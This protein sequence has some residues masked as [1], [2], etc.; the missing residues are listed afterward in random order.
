MEGQ[1]IPF[2]FGVEM[3]FY[4][5]WHLEGHDRPAAPDEFRSHPGGPVTIARQALEMQFPL[6]QTAVVRALEQAIANLPQDDSLPIVTQPDILYNEWLIGSDASLEA[7]WPEQLPGDGE[8]LVEAGSG[9]VG[10]E[11]VSPAL[12]ATQRSIEEIRKVCRFLYKTFWI[13]TPFQAGLHVHVG[14][15]HAWLP[16]ASLRRMAALLYSADPILAQMYPPYRI[17][18]FYCPSTRLYATVSFGAKISEDYLAGVEYQPEDSLPPPSPMKAI[19]QKIYEGTRAVFQLPKDAPKPE[20]KRDVNF[21]PRP[22]KSALVIQPGTALESANFHPGME[23]R[24]LADF[25]NYR[26]IPMMDAVSELL[27]A[28]N[29]NRL[30][31]LMRVA[32]GRGAYN[33]NEFITDRKRTIE[34]RR[35]AATVDPVQVVSQVRIAVRLCQF[36]VESSDEAFTNIILDCAQGEVTPEYFDIYDLLQDLDLYPEARIVQAVTTNSLNA[37]IRNQ[38]WLSCG[39]PISHEDEEDEKDD[40]VDGVIYI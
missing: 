30:G 26:P 6:A 17:T 28:T 39:N 19:M 23:R 27:R 21:P 11:I 18:H 4:I 38:Y 9:W 24:K 8:E 5:A 12:W 3:E 22:T 33:C 16:I 10:V 20:R 29:R 34:F 32:P 37:S 14:T 7:E 36:A 40:D 35:G 15:G 13:F 25:A 1:R 31:V 2:S